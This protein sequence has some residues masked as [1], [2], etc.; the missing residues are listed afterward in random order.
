MRRIIKKTM[1]RHIAIIM[2]GNGR[3]AKKNMFR[4][5]VGHEKGAQ[6]VRTVV[7]V[8]RELGVGYLT[9][10]AFSVEN[11]D[12]PKTEV[13]ALML[14]L[15]KYLETE[16]ARMKETGIR[17]LTIGDTEN[18]PRRVKNLLAKTIE[19]TSKNDGMVLTLALSYGGRDEI[20]RAV[21]GILRDSK[22][23][24]ITEDM[25][26]KDFFSR[27]LYTADVPDPDLM[28]RT[29][30]EYR[31]SNF[32]LW[33]LAYAELYYTDVLWPDFSKDDLIEAIVD[34][35]HRE[36]RFGLTSDQLPGD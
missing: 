26:T 16:M 7:E 22:K 24:E 10:Y 1:P 30:G 27:Y 29:S 9:L 32:L 14:L 8:C 23:S 21:K 3:W 12:R 36:R 34:Y 13:S 2:D 25:V 11:W 31:I 5:G 35:Q 19:E 15:E 33:Q 6:A 17:L 4:R 20:I 18:L 28:I